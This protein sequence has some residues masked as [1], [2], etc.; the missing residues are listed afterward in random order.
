MTDNACFLRNIFEKMCAI[1]NINQKFKHTRVV[2][3]AA[4]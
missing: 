1:Q 3:K 2:N 4:I